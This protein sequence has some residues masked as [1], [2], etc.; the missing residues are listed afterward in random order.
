MHG[1]VL[2]HLRVRHD[3][4]QGPRAKGARLPRDAVHEAARRRVFPL[5]ARDD[6]GRADRRRVPRAVVR[7]VLPERGGAFH[8]HDVFLRVDARGAH[9]VV[10]RG[11]ALVSASRAWG[12]A[13]VPLQPWPA[14]LAEAEACWCGDDFSAENPPAATPF[15]P[16]QHARHFLPPEEHPKTLIAMHASCLLESYAAGHANVV[17]SVGGREVS[18]CA[19]CAFEDKVA[20][21][22]ADFAAGFAATA[23]AWVAAAA[24]CED[25]PAAAAAAAFD[26]LHVRVDGATSWT[27]DAFVAATLAALVALHPQRLYR[28]L[29]ARA[30]AAAAVPAAAV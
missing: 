27:W 23:A 7:P 22:S 24:A 18:S 17:L 5:H 26:A 2:L 20:A 28:Q 15:C 8:E 21:I 9:T 12:A 11:G 19:T 10:R 14:A 1:A 4:L 13:D 6:G 16:R 3:T 25:A 30:A 29:A